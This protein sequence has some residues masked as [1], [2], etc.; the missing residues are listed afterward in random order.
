MMLSPSSMKSK[1]PIA[2]AW[3]KPFHVVCCHCFHLFHFY[4]F[5]RVRHFTRYFLLCLP[6]CLFHIG[7]TL[8]HDTFHPVSHSPVSKIFFIFFAL[9]VTLLFAFFQHWMYRPRWFFRSWLT[10]NTIIFLVTLQALFFFFSTYLA[11]KEDW[12]TG[13]LS[14]IHT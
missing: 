4:N 9:F 14:Q 7:W 2:A 12:F 6:H 11:E 13:L 10:L 5:H 1:M 3:C 8:D